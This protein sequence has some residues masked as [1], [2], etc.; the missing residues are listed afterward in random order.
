MTTNAYIFM[1]DCY[2]IESIVPITQYEHW[3]HENLLKLLAD[4]PTVRNPINSIIQRLIIRA[5]FNTQRNYEIYAVNCNEDMDESFWKLQWQTEPQQ[6]AGLIR[7]HGMKIY[8]DRA[9][10]LHRRV[11]T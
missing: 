5:R 10:D 1:W 3:D 9:V 2:G 8:S 6:T 4:K 7:Q 11:I